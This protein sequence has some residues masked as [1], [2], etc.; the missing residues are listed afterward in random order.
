[1]GTGEIAL[2]SLNWLLENG[3]PDDQIVGIFTQT[4]KKIGRKQI[5]TPPEVKVI[6][7]RHSIPVFQPERFRH[8]EEALA[9]LHSLDCDLAVVMAYG[10]ILPDEVIAIPRIACVNLHASLL[11]RHRGASPIQAA[12]RDGD[13][14]SGI[15]LM[16]IKAALDAGDMIIKKAIPIHPEDTGSSLHDRL[17]V[18]GPGILK[19]GLPLL[20]A[21]NA[22]REVQD[23]S[24]VTISGKLSR[25]DGEI[26]W[27]K[28]AVEIERLIR[29]Y[30]PWPGTHTF[31]A[32]D[33]G[34]KK[35]KIFPGN[36]IGPAN[37]DSPGTIISLHDGI[38]VSCGDGSSLIIKGDI[39]LE[40]RKRLPVAEFLRGTS[41][42]TGIKFGKN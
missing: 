24:L 28:P 26:D 15:T 23:E 6:G 31:L 17:A 7:Q 32:D 41:I 13:R 39:Q 9:Q 11:P 14:E 21:G 8:N 19:E 10:Q 33:S 18:L 29:A 36:T 2:P 25:E 3:S 5:L 35:I 16:H 42:S 1:M 37:E 30:H 22:P 38:T 4:D 12:I 20:A 40:G 27:S 34:I